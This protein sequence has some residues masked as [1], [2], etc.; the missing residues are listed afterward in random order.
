MADSSAE[1]RSGERF[2]F[3]ENWRRFLDLL[4]EDRIAEA[5][6]SLTKRLGHVGGLSLVDVGSG[7]G[8][9]SLAARNLGARVVSF[10]YDGESVACTEEVRRRYRPEDPDWSVTDGSALDRSFLASL[11]TFDIVYSWGV[12]HHSGNMWRALGLVDQ[13]VAPGGRLFV[14]IY[15]DQGF[16]SRN[17]KRIKKAYVGG[18]RMK[19]CAVLGAVTVYFAYRRAMADAMSIRYRTARALHGD[20][21]ARDVFAGD[22]GPSNPRG[23]D[24]RR[25]ILD[26]VGGY[27]FEVAKPEEIFDFYRHR[28]FVLECL[29]TCAGGHGC[30]EFVFTRS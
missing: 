22:E 27:P 14:S 24:R 12:L 25:D 23:M 1:I 13:L 29:T 2:A 11:G 7:S 21:P 19:R 20:L 10:D 18:G 15:N 28:G 3:G 17:W 8:L 4:N 30:N 5:Q 9:F 16:A 6:E 26:W